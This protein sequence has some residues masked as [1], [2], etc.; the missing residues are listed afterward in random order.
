MLLP[1]IPIVRF[2]V[3]RLNGLIESTF[4]WSLVAQI[5]QGTLLQLE[6][7]LL[8][9]PMYSVNMA[10]SDYLFR[11][12][13]YGLVGMRV[14]KYG[15]R[16]ADGCK[17]LQKVVETVLI[18]IYCTTINAFFERKIGQNIQKHLI[19]KG[20]GE[21]LQKWVKIF[22]ALFCLS[23]TFCLVFFFFF[24]NHIV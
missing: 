1:R 6:G 18:N 3:Q 9:H 24:I 16:S 5:V 4:F 11:S 8:P 22:D 2:W 10:P 12:M 14:K 7:V 13:Q 23:I 21:E 20:N 17:M 19:L 15:N